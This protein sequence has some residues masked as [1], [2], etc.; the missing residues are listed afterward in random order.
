MWGNIIR[1][2][3]NLF[4]VRPYTPPAPKQSLPPLV[5]NYT[6]PS[7]VNFQPSYSPTN[8]S[9]NYKSLTGQTYVPGT[10]GGT[11]SDSGYTRPPASSFARPQTDFGSLLRSINIGQRSL[12]ENPIIKTLGQAPRFGGQFLPGSTLRQTLGNFVDAA[13]KFGFEQ[14]REKMGLNPD[15]GISEAI[16]GKG[17]L[18]TA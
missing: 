15:L 16:A 10:S 13:S 2:I 12:S 18:N 8:F 1:T 7:P 17:T 4:R 9:S 6:Q 3:G 14:I 5:T 11:T